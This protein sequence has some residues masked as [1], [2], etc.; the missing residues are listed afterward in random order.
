MLKARHTGTQIRAH[1]VI[2]GDAGDRPA[3]L[4]NARRPHPHH[5]QIAHIHATLIDAHRPHP[6][7]TQ[8][9]HIHCTPRRTQT[10]AHQVMHCV[11]GDA[12]DWHSTFINNPPACE[13]RLHHYP[14]TTT[15]TTTTTLFFQANR[16]PQT[17]EYY[18]GTSHVYESQPGASR[19]KLKLECGMWASGIWT[20]GFEVRDVHC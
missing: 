11:D 5:T 2:A 13:P 3:T 7:H 1:Q 6:H 19:M 10:R 14:A 9:A 12:G 15:T 16:K 8:I 20:V 4:I 18:R 17:T